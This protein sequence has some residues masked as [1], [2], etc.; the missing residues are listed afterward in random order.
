MTRDRASSTG[1][2]RPA[3]SALPPHPSASASASAGLKGVVLA[4]VV[5]SVMLLASAVLF[6][7][8]PGQLSEARDFRAARPCAELGGSAA[9]NGDCLA[10]R[11]ATVLGTEARRRGKGHAR[12]VTLDPGRGSEPFH[13]R[14]R[15][16]RPVWEKLA[17]GDRVTVSSWRGRTVQVVAGEARQD[18]IDR[19]GPGAI[20]R[21]AVALALLI[22]GCVFVRSAFWWNG[23][24]VP[25]APA[26][27]AAQV[28]V[29]MVA[30]ASAVGVA[31]TAAV[32]VES[33]PLALLATA[34]GCAVLW[35]ASAW[36]L[37]RP[38]RGR[39]ARGTV[40]AP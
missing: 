17:P 3:P 16:E 21:L 22:V 18:A 5:G 15:G 23:R 34:A 35:A 29:P 28:T 20:V 6:A 37:R 8:L 33:L 30:T 40:S 2:S 27:R 7:L 1:P 11:P 38:A 9:E 12:W 14:L 13:V 26:V 10:E 36:L 31:V 25:G 24:R 32:T 4:A 19:P 39:T